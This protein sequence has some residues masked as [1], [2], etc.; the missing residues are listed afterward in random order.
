M[1]ISLSAHYQRF[2]PRFGLAVLESSRRANW[3]MLSRSEVT[4]DFNQAENER[5]RVINPRPLNLQ[6]I[7]VQGFVTRQLKAAGL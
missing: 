1:P 3:K 5:M 4:T 7:V 2:K 6:H